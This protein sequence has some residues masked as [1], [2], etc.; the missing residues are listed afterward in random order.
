MSTVASNDTG[1]KN[2]VG[3]VGH[4]RWTIVLTVFGLITFDYIDRGLITSALPVLTTLFK[5]NGV[6]QAVIGD[7]FTYGY[8]IMNPVIGYLIDR[9]GLRKS[10]SA[11]GF[12]W[13]AVQFISAGAF[14]FV[15]L[16][17]ARVFL[18][19]AEAVGFPGATKITSIWLTK[20]EKARG[21]TISDSGV[22]VGIILGSL[23]LLGFNA[24]APSVIAWR[25]ALMF[26]GAITIIM[27][28]V[29]VHFLFNSPEQHP[30]ISKAELDYIRQNQDSVVDQSKVKVSQWF[31]TRDYWGFQQGLAAQ[32]GIFFG[33]LTF[34]PLYLSFSRHFSI[35]FTLGYTALIWGMGF[36]GE[37]TGGFVV[38]YLIKRFSPNVGMK[39]GF[40]VSS[41]GVTFGLLAATFASSGIEAVEIL[42]ITFFALRWSGIQWSAASFIVPQKYSGQWGGHIGFWETLWGIVIPLV[43]GYT[44]MR[45]SAYTTGM[46]IMVLVGVIY[47][48]GAVL[49]TRYK[50]LKLGNAQS[51]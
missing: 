40:S 27:V 38:D 30:R 19:I 16:A 5:L 4:I 41:L 32:A 15:Y 8:L 25:Y 1:E 23:V 3:G 43:F 20:S 45:T 14:S 6:E 37:I 24:I 39:V 46:I 29:L 28:Y 47:F 31:K 34:L 50:P 44:L 12:A 18:G 35:S 51:A 17:F 42:M 26:S 11:S 9:Y 7:G 49:V 13:G 2:S 33:L 48:V 10:I 22:N 36:I 21:G